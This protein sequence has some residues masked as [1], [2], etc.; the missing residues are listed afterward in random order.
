MAAPTESDHTFTVVRP[1]SSTRSTAKITNT[2][3]YS[4]DAYEMDMTVAIESPEMGTMTIAASS[5][6]KLIGECPAE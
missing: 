2:G 3:T 1:M 5:K 4:E 6:G